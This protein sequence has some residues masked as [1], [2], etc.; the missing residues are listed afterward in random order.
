MDSVVLHL[1]D[2]DLPS[3]PGIVLTSPGSQGLHG[4]SNLGECSAYLGQRDVPGVPNV[5][6]DVNHTIKEFGPFLGISSPGALYSVRAKQQVNLAPA[7]EC[8]KRQ[9]PGGATG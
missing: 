3:S 1:G 9:L 2:A 5:R 6:A 4:G 7:D 8:L